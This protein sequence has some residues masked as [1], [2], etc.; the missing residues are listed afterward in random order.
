MDTIFERITYYDLYGYTIP[1]CFL[2]MLCFAKDFLHPP[3]FLHL[4]K[5][6]E[7]IIMT[8]ISESFLGF[9]YGL[10]YKSHLTESTLG[11][12]YEVIKRA[13]VK[14]GVVENMM[15]I[16]N[17]EDVSRYLWYMYGS[18]QADKS[19]N[20]IHNYASSQLMYSNLFLAICVGGVIAVAR[21]SLRFEVKCFVDLFVIG[22]SVLLAVRSEQFRVK[23]EVYA[24]YWFI[25]KQLGLRQAAGS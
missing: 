20:R 24:I 2:L 13:L 8:Q 22:I 1:G 21:L 16:R 9:L 23:K 14:A 3:L 6:P 15:V 11:I 19:Y 10:R 18:V 4:E 17:P 12:S 7:G 5:L 25:E